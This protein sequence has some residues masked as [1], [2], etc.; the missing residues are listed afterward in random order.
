MIKPKYP[1]LIDTPP[2]NAASILPMK[3]NELPKNTG[4]LNFVNNK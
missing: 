4:L 3:A 1:T 2:A